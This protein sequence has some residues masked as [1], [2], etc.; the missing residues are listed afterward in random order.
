MPRTTA[1]DG[2][3]ELLGDSLA[4]A[5]TQLAGQIADEN[6]LD[7]RTMG[8]LGFNGA[9]ML[10]DVSKAVANNARRFTAK[11]RALQAAL[12][13]LAIGLPAAALLIALA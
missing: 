1:N 7:G 10:E 3:P 13:I 5:R 4:L 2:N 12:V 9:L 6:S 11:R 8:T